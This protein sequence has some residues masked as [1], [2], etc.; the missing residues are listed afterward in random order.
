MQFQ[1]VGSDGGTDDMDVRPPCPKCRMHMI[2]ITAIKNN[3]QKFECL[4]CGYLEVRMII[5]SELTASR[6]ERRR[7]T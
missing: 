1:L 6:T 7:S 2:A 5:E 3:E 4:R